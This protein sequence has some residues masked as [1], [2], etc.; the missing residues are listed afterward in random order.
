MRLLPPLRVRLAP[1]DHDR[2]GADW[3]PYDEAA[4]LRLP[5]RELVDIEREIGMSLSR[6]LDRFRGGYTDGNLAALWLA[7][8]AAG[9][10]E[11]FA[12]FAPLALLAEWE[13]PAADDV[14]PPAPTSSTSPETA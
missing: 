10:D 9:I 1:E 13:R 3:W 4:L 14:D 7:R 5:A 8:R 11:D 6:V 2:Y 12:D